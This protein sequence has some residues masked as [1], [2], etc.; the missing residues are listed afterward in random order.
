MRFSGATRS[1][2]EEV[3]P[4]LEVFASGQFQH[5]RLVHAGPRLKVERV[6]RLMRGKSSRF[7]TPVGSPPF[8][9]DQLQLAQLQEKGQV[10]E[11]LLPGMRGHLLTLGQ[12]RGQFELL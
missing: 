2:E 3:L 11:I 10:I 6:E 7:Q 1:D 12:H 8:P 4:P 5:K 9:I